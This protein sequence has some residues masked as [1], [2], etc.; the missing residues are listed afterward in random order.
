MKGVGFMVGRFS[1]KGKLLSLSVTGKIG[2][3][4]CEF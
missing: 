4:I 3:L 2:I 1:G